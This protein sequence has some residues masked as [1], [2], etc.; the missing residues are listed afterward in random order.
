MDV[1]FAIVILSESLLEVL[2]FTVKAFRVTD[3]LDPPGKCRKNG[4]FLLWVMV[5]AGM[6]VQ[7]HMYEFSVDHMPQQAV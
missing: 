1:R 2:E 7:L 4:T 3:D 6:Q 5:G